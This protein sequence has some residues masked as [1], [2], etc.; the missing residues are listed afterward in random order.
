MAIFF[1]LSLQSATR[2]F[3][4]RCVCRLCL[5]LKYRGLSLDPSLV[6]S[7]IL[8]EA[9]SKLIGSNVRNYLTFYT[10]VYSSLCVLM[11]AVKFIRIR[12]R[13]KS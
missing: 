9:N 4:R 8:D 12:F 10:H 13:F 3:S 5:C 7:F 6:W 11:F 1:F 2:Q